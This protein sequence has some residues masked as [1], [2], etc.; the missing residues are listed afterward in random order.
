MAKLI[1]VAAYDTR[2]RYKHPQPGQAHRSEE[3]KSVLCPVQAGCRGAQRGSG[4]LSC[5]AHSALCFGRGMLLKNPSVGCRGLPCIRCITGPQLTRGC[6]SPSSA[7]PRVVGAGSGPVA[8]SPGLELREPWWEMTAKAIKIFLEEPDDTIAPALKPP[9]MQPHRR[10]SCC[11]RDLFRAL[12]S[13]LSRGHWCWEGG[14]GKKDTPEATDSFSPGLGLYSLLS[15][16][17]FW[18]QCLE[19]GEG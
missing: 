9:A 17:D 5:C 15:L 8:P 11:R 18:L 10:A 14:N 3:E 2:P 7:Q 1:A 6:V 12:L 19:A 4:C 13:P 16:G